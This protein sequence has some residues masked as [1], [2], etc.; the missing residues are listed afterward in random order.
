MLNKYNDDACSA[1]TMAQLCLLPAQWLLVRELFNEVSYLF[2]KS[3]QIN[4]VYFRMSVFTPEW[5]AAVS[6][7]WPLFH[8]VTF[9]FVRSFHGTGASFVIFTK[10]EQHCLSSRQEQRTEKIEN[11]S[12][13]LLLSLQ[14]ANKRFSGTQLST[15]NFSTDDSWMLMLDPINS[16]VS[17]HGTRIGRMN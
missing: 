16:F 17:R 12:K 5:F 4:F 1:L 15:F 3:L 8:A 10:Q 14:P 2:R 9:T 11:N 13:W 6:S 7:C